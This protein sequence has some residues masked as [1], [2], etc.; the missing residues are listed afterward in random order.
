MTKLLYLVVSADGNA[1]FSTRPRYLP[2]TRTY[3]L[4]ITI[5][6]PRIIV[7]TIEVDAPFAVETASAVIDEP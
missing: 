6:D 7:G 1:K 3:L 5:P 2:G 4:T